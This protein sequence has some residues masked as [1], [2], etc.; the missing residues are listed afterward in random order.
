MVD[1]IYSLFLLFVIYP[2]IGAVWFVVPTLIVYVLMHRFIRKTW[3]IPCDFIDIPTLVVPCCIWYHFSQID[4]MGR[5]LGL[6]IDLLAIGPVYGI[7]FL[8][9]AIVIWFRPQWRLK[10][11]LLMLVLTTVAM[12][13]FALTGIWGKE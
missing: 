12:L 2:G 1:S 11:S 9:R 6:F 4:S 5:G 8:I 3:K 13:V 7:L 10:A